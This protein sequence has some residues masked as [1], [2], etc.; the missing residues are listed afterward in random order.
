MIRSRRGLGVAAV[1]ASSALVAASLVAAPALGQGGTWGAV[2]PEASRTGVPDW[3]RPGTRIV[4]YV[5]SAS[6]PQS[7]YALV[8]DP[9]GD[10]ENPRTGKK[11]RRTDES[12]EGVGG[13]SGQGY[14][15]IDVVSVTPDTVVG[16]VSLFTID[17][18]TGALTYLPIGGGP[19]PAGA[20]DAV[21]L[22]PSIVADLVAAGQA[23]GADL[24]VG[25]YPLGGVTYDVAALVSATQDVSIDRASGVVVAAAGNVAGSISPVRLEG[26]DPPVGNSLRTYQQLLGTRDR[27]LAGVSAPVPAWVRGNPTLSYDGTFAIGGAAVP[28]R[29]TLTV[30]E[31]G[32]DWARMHAVTEVGALG[33][34]STNEAWVVSGGTGPFWY[35]PVALAS[36]RPGD[37]LDRDALTGTT[38]RV[39]DSGTWAGGSYVWIVTEGPGMSMWFQYDVDTGVPMGY[40]LQQGGSDFTVWLTAMP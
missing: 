24:L 15:V 33:A 34:V 12:G 23:P 39:A 3:V 20:M 32:A 38:T 36:F 18:A 26:E 29:T 9:N 1:L 14:S 10:L 27:A 11:Y 17:P 31:V 2:F 19:E 28:A 21:W 22:H 25:P 35:D 13:G 4:Q 7:R 5:A 30:V 8:E 37:E 6:I 40:S 16:A